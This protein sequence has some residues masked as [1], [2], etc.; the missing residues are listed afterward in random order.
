M[1]SFQI[2]IFLHPTP[3]FNHETNPVFQTLSPFRREHVLYLLTLP[4]VV[5]II[6]GLQLAQGQSLQSR[7][8]WQVKVKT[9]EIQLLTLMILSQGKGD[10]QSQYTLVSIKQ[11]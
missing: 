11:V 10:N 7:R 4:D 6:T 3:L 8:S 2:L 5:V 9:N 1:K